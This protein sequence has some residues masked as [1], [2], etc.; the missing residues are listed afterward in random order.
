MKQ[1]KA[2]FPF[3]FLEGRQ[4]LCGLVSFTALSFGGYSPLLDF[5]RYAGSLMFAFSGV[6][7][8]LDLESFGRSCPVETGCEW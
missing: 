8:D 4:D 3:Y 2:L 5:S 6:L 7:F 1:S